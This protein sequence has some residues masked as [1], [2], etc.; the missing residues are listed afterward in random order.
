MNLQFK[1]YK[2]IKN[3]FRLCNRAELCYEKS[4][5]L[6]NL[7]LLNPNKN[8]S[9]LISILYLAKEIEGFYNVITFLHNLVFL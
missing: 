9:K 6:S 2:K 1:L 7:E 3:V 5:C 8:V 4:F